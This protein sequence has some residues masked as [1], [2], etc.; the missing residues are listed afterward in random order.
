MVSV[1]QESRCSLA[2]VLWLKVS[3]RWKSKCWLGLQSHLKAWLKGIY[4]PA[5]SSELVSCGQRLPQFLPHGPLPS[6]QHA[7]WLSSEWA[8][9]EPRWKSECVDDLNLEVTSCCLLASACQKWV[10]RPSSRGRRSHV[11][12]NTRWNQGD[13]LGGSIP[14]P[15]VQRG[16]LCHG[17]AQPSTSSRDSYTITLYYS[18]EWGHILMALWL[19]FTSEPVVFY[20]H[21]YFF[22]ARNRVALLSYLT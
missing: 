15:S 22:P 5:H 17:P 19:L 14:S 18:S 9:G 3:H 6:W 4:F 7:S 10:A 13:P 16:L 2:W 8:R 1:G 21:N 20:N 11:A 12:M